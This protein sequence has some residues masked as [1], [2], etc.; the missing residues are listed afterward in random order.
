MALRTRSK[1]LGRTLNRY[2]QL[3]DG[4]NGW[5]VRSEPHCSRAI[6]SPCP[7]SICLFICTPGFLSTLSHMLISNERRVPRFLPVVPS[8]FAS[9]WSG[10][11]DGFVVHHT[12]PANLV[13][14]DASQSV[15]KQ[16]YFISSAYESCYTRRWLDD[17]F[18][19]R[20]KYSFAYLSLGIIGL[21]S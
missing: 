19:G 13:G 10:Y 8:L 17:H 4:S 6:L 15:G 5:T 3:F 14:E 1:D 16:R 7:H 2:W 18:L 21:F 20:E 11:W 9:E 12:D